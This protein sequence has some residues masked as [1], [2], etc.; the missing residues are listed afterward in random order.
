MI[1]IIFVSSFSLYS[2]NSKYSQKTCLLMEGLY[3][4]KGKYIHDTL[5]EYG[6]GRETEVTKGEGEKKYTG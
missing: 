3:I 5:C 4:L 1:L 2:E 6:G